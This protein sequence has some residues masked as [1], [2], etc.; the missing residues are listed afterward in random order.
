[1]TPAKAFWT[2]RRQVELNRALNIALTS[3][4]GE[5]DPKVVNIR[6]MIDS[7][8][9][10][11]AIGGMIRCTSNP[12]GRTA[13]GEDVGDLV[14]S[15]YL[16]DRWRGASGASLAREGRGLDK[17][18]EELADRLDGQPSQDVNRLIEAGLA[19][20]GDDEN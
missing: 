1:M 14:A 6:T 12:K 5:G 8:D 18:P 17:L 20:L 7:V 11:V 16:C 2:E 10:A 19:R 9:N 3:P 13:T 15:N 4:L